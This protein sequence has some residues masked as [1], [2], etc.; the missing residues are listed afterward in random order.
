MDHQEKQWRFE[1][2][3]DREYA[4][5]QKNSMGPAHV[6]GAGGRRV[7]LT[8]KQQVQDQGMAGMLKWSIASQHRNNKNSPFY[9]RAF[10]AGQ[11][12]E[13]TYRYAHQREEKQHRS[14]GM[15]R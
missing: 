4:E 9:E 5:E 11:I 13:W 10:Q 2:R 14:R 12:S 15:S 3:Q 8:G 7:N 6:R 1:Q